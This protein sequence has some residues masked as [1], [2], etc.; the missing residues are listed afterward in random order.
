[1]AF[2]LPKFQ[3]IKKIL[4]PIMFQNYSIRY[5]NKIIYSYSPLQVDSDVDFDEIRNGLVGFILRGVI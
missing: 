2:A 4:K 3:V 5:F 1:M